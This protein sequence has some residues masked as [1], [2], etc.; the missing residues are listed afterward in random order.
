M[1]KIM[2]FLLIVSMMAALI[3]FGTCAAEQPDE[4]SIEEN[5][6]ENKTTYPYIVR[7]E[8]AIWYLAGD[9]I[10]LMGKDAFTRA[11]PG[12][13]CVFISSDGGISASEGIAADISQ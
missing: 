9:D 1:K 2:A 11:F 6:A 4:Y 3:A 5:T 12:T 7:T 8:S 13:Q 10:D